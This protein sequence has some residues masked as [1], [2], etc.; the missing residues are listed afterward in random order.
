M[1]V[2]SISPDDFFL[3]PNIQNS[4]IGRATFVIVAI[5]RNVSIKRMNDCEKC[6]VI[7]YPLKQAVLDLNV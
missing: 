4:I 6:S 1:L 2:I 7:K 5:Q 3:H